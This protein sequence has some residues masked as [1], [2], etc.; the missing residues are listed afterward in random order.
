MSQIRLSFN[1]ASNNYDNH[2][3]LQKEIAIRLDKK[4]NTI[5][6]KA[7]IILDL[8]AGTGLLSKQLTKCF[9]NSKIICI[10]FSQKSLKY[11]PSSNKICANANYLPLLNNSID[12]I[13]SNLMM[14]WCPDL[15]TLFSECFRVLKND[16]LFLFSTFG[17][18]TLKELKN[19]WSVVDDKIHVNTFID[20]HDI[21][22]QM[23]QNRFQNPVMEMETWTL[24]YQTV[25]DLLHDLKAI[26]A[27]T[28]IK[29]SKSLTGKNKFRLMIKMYESYKNNG[30]LPVTYEVIYGHAWKQTS[31]IANITLET[32]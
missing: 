6:S 17:P 21:G 23:L 30:K 1:K 5:S 4:L 9:L 11:N 32:Q 24:T 16:G 28:V 26:G 29:R 27:Q 13:T 15:N 3:L 7:D 22:D 31:N 25:I 2:A 10:D 14:Q 20:M 18:D 12:I 19:S 8:G